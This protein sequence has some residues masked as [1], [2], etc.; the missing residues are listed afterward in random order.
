M[1]VCTY[2]QK[3]RKIKCIK[4]RD[5]GRNYEVYDEIPSTSTVY[6]SNSSSNLDIKSSTNKKEREVERK[7]KKGEVRK[8]KISIKI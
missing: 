6:T 8:T 3:H 1:Q 7:K 4:F 2:S 5:D